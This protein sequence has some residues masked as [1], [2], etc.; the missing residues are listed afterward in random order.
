MYAPLLLASGDID[1]AL[2]IVDEVLAKAG[3]K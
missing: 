2:K 1:A 3:K